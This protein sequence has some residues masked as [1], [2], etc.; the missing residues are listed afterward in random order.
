MNIDIQDI[1]SLYRE[2]IVEELMKPPL[3]EFVF[4]LKRKPR[5]LPYWIWGRLVSW[6]MDE[7]YVWRAELRTLTFAKYAPLSKLTDG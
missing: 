3:W 5:W 6:M 7:K 4:M 1:A 2:K